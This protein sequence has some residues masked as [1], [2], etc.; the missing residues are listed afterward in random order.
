MAQYIEYKA[1]LEGIKV[2]FVKPEYTS[3]I[4]SVCG[5]KNKANDRKYKC[6]CGF[7]THR[8]ILG[9]RNIIN[10]PVADGNSLSA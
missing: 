2:E 3:Q 1:I 10:A 8:D 9:A 4:C 6:K 5:E 7:K